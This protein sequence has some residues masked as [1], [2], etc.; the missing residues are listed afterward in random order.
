MNT[1]IFILL[2][3]LTNFSSHFDLFFIAVIFLDN[4][5]H[6]PQIAII[7]GRDVTTR[8]ISAFD[9]I[10]LVT[11]SFAIG[12]ILLKGDTGRLGCSG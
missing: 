1:L 10:D 9:C 7:P 8:T 5:A 2:S 12:Y 6:T 3:R 11:R 4:V